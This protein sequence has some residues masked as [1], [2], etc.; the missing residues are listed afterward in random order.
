MATEIL[1]RYEPGSSHNALK[2]KANE[3]GPYTDVG[4]LP[5]KSFGAG[6]GKIF[7]LTSP[8]IER[9]SLISQIYISWN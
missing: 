2:A 4:W 7:L 8:F 6:W 5:K 9:I 3:A 1:W